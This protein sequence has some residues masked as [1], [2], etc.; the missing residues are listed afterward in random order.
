MQAGLVV[1]LLVITQVEGQQVVE[2]SI[3]TDGVAFRVEGIGGA[4]VLEVVFPLS[5]GVD[6]VGDRDEV[7]EEKLPVDQAQHQAKQEPCRQVI[8]RRLQFCGLQQFL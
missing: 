6:E 2:F 5:Q 7:K 8:F 4:P 3:T 1:V